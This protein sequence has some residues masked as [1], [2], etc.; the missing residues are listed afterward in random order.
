MTQ[1]LKPRPV[2]K[3]QVVAKKKTTGQPSTPR[4]KSTPS[5]SK[6]YVQSH[7]SD[8]VL[9]E[10]EA[11]LNDFKNRMTINNREIGYAWGDFKNVLTKVKDLTNE[12][13][14]S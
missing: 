2:Y 10:R 4:T 5:L 13:V 12:L 9:I 8:I 11:L 14:N 7:L 3:K 1:T 6:P